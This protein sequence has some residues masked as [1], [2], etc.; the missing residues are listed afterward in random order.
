MTTSQKTRISQG[1]WASPGPRRRWSAAHRQGRE[2]D[3]VPRLAGQHG[4]RRLHLLRDDVPR[5]RRCVRTDCETRDGRAIKVEGNPDHPVEP[6]RALRAR[7]GWLQALYNPDRYRGPMMRRNGKLVPTT[8]DEA[9]KLFGQK[10]P[11]RE[12]RRTTPRSSISTSRERSPRSSMSGSPATE[13]PAHQLRRRCGL[14]G[15]RREQ[16]VVR[17]GVADASTSAP[18]S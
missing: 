16:P 17:R 1:P 6:R 3:S 13:C 5:V 8:W 9:L 12:A 10:L 4:A 7:P 18:P 2:A 15:H 14:R 11:R